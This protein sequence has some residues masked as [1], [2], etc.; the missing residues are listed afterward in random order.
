MFKRIMVP[1]DLAHKDKQTRAL[2]C[3]AD[4]ARLYDVPL[5]YV[6]VTAETPGSLGHN[7]AEYSEKLTAFATAEGQARGIAA[8]AHMEL[9]HDPTSDMDDCL[10]RAIDATGSDLVVMASHIP[11]LAEY[12]W[13]SNGGKVAAHAKVSVMVVRG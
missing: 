1:I 7:P 2:Q 9:S 13:P 10:L 11:G 6:G 5:V 8:S 3:G 4:L 12:I